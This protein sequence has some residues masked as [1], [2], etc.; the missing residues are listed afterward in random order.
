M[1]VCSISGAYYF[2]MFKEDFTCYWIVHFVRLRNFV[3]LY[4]QRWSDALLQDKKISLLQNSFAKTITLPPFPLPKTPDRVDCSST[5]PPSVR[6]SVHLSESHR[7]SREEEVK[8]CEP[9]KMFVEEIGLGFARRKRR[10]E[11]HK[12]RVSWSFPNHVNFHLREKF[13]HKN[14]TE[15]VPE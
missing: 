11:G 4:C 10:K 13:L 3:D 15:I 8:E 1:S 6:E 5:T 12:R 7:R 9:Y 2:A 14:C